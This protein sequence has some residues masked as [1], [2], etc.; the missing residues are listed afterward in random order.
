MGLTTEQIWALHIISKLGI[1]VDNA[2]V[3]DPEHYS[4]NVIDSKILNY[5][6]LDGYIIFCVYDRTLHSP[7][8][9][10]SP[11]KF[12][13]AVLTDRGRELVRDTHIFTGKLETVNK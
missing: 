11:D 7:G 6:F 9:H 8:E 3:G 12:T 2:G 1:Y 13:G 4:S 5:L 10:S